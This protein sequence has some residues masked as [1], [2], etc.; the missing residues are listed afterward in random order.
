M[1]QWSHS[2]LSTAYALPQKKDNI[3][4]GTNM[5]NPTVG[6]A[7]SLDAPK[8]VQLKT[9]FG[10]PNKHVPPNPYQ[11]FLEESQA[12]PQAY[13]GPNSYLSMV[14]ITGIVDHDIWAVTKM[15]PWCLHQS[16]MEIVWDRWYFRD[17]MMGRTPEESTSRMLES[18]FSTDRTFVVRYG[19]SLQL[20]HGFYNTAKGRFTYQMNLLQIRHAVT[21]T[22][23]YGAFI[24]CL[25]AKPYV[26]AS[27]DFRGG[28][29][30][31]VALDAYIRSLTTDWACVQ[32]SKNGW[33][34]I[35]EKYD[36]IGLIQGGEKPNMVIAPMEMAKFIKEA[37]GNEPF[38]LNGKGYNHPTNVLTD[39]DYWES[40]PFKLGER[41]ETDDPCYR[42]QSIGSRH[43]MLNK[44]IRDLPVAQY[45]TRFMN[46]TIFNETKDGWA[47]MN[48]ADNV[49]YLGLYD[50]WDSAKPTLSK[51]LGQGW[52]GPYQNW[53]NICQKAGIDRKVAQ[54]INLL[55][56][57]KRLEF[58]SFA[59]TKTE[60][61]AVQPFLASDLPVA[62][63]Q[64]QAYKPKDA[65]YNLI[66]LHRPDG[67]AVDE[68][69]QI[70][71]ANDKGDRKDLNGA[72]QS[73]RYDGEILGPV[74]NDVLNTGMTALLPLDGPSGRL[75]KSYSLSYGLSHYNMLV[76]YSKKPNWI[77][78]PELLATIVTGEHEARIT[79]QVAGLVLSAI[80]QYPTESDA[81][82]GAA[83]KF[84]NK[85]IA[86]KKWA[87]DAFNL[88]LD[89]YGGQ[90][91]LYTAYDTKPII[92]AALK[93]Y[94]T[95]GSVAEVTAAVQ[96]YRN[97][98]SISRGVSRVSMY[99]HA[100]SAARKQL[101]EQRKNS[102]DKQQAKA[103]SCVA[104]IE[105]SL[106]LNDLGLAA[107]DPR[108]ARF[109]SF[110]NGY[111]D[112][113]VDLY[114]VVVREHDTS[115]NYLTEHQFMTLAVML[116]NFVSQNEPNGREEV[117]FIINALM[118]HNTSTEAKKMCTIL[119]AI[120]A[121][122]S[123]AECEA[124]AKSFLTTDSGKNIKDLTKL[125]AS[126]TSK[127]EAKLAQIRNLI[128]GQ[129]SLISSKSYTMLLVIVNGRTKPIFSKL[130]K[131]LKLAKV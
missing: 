24:A 11:S 8:D 97:V 114:C 107:Q 62:H 40:R 28:M 118:H 125:T 122:G 72:E 3:F 19:L 59:G 124:H 30:N 20:E 90:N 95:P 80:A 7:V 74:N 87:A 109:T 102:A 48:Y 25:Q 32:K 14:M 123:M 110:F 35:K 65:A 92:A 61:P 131:K 70:G 83:E 55:S 75:D 47:T 120:D 33:N 77:G 45:Q 88:A 119:N 36:K 52:L 68:V 112:I 103:E 126:I 106:R 41:Q 2:G 104:M 127:T 26:D 42:E 58:L 64:A 60:L 23:A 121:T 21:E 98:Q 43:Y 130:I 86:S 78:R 71:I 6:G 84:A 50:N 54:K 53:G 89:N 66:H 63:F 5:K 115:K 10:I 111:K 34:R 9:F 29:Q 129:Q 51:S 22:C 27:L 37:S 56:A 15:L 94:R 49:R 38:Y 81:I 79:K 13:E 85:F 16:S 57:R 18:N 101:E 96:K 4:D 76:E 82:K 67:L 113:F 46:T 39:G 44:H 108:K 99:D 128:N 91:P 1:P 69:I 117:M 105:E 93:L 12:L 116:N 31:A 17:A 100:V 73:V